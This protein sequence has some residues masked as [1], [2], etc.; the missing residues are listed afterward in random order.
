MMSRL[1]VS[2]MLLVIC[3]A[4]TA[5]LSSCK[6]SDG[7]DKLVGRLPIG[8]LDDAIAR[9]P[10]GDQAYRDSV[11]TLYQQP[12][13]FLFSLIGRGEVTDSSIYEYACSRPVK[14]FTHITDS[15][16]GD[17]DSV[18]AI[19][20]SIDGRIRKYLPAAAIGDVY[21]IVS[22]YNQSIFTTDSMMLIGL[23]HYL[24]AD[25][26]GYSYFEPYQRI[27]KR[28]DQLPYDVVEA[29]VGSAYPMQRE[30]GETVLTNLLYQGAVI[31]AKMRLVPDADLAAALGYTADQ[32]AWMQ[33]NEVPAWDAL[34]A[35]RIL[36]STSPTDAERL[37]LP[38]PATTILHPDAPGRAGRYIGYKIVRA[39][40][41]THP[42]VTLE[43]LLS[44]EFY[45]GSQTLLNA[46]Y[47]PEAA[48]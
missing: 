22:P 48:K 43:E 12:L 10:V 13:S 36:Y 26:D 9:Y 32:L 31:E 41:D 3:C 47:R 30:K 34:I 20:G 27:N 24:G 1:C 15:L 5:I 17:L 28:I 19:F 46:G 40:M 6:M 14:V 21:A 2:K 42:S 16:L 44:P 29:A 25:F 8:R 23:N 38:S 11:Q 35:R 39:Y 18:E 33:A 4:A 37:I 45:A 7:S